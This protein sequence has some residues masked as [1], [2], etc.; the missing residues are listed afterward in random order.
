MTKPYN[1][2]ED[3]YQRDLVFDTAQGKTLPLERILKR[4][5]KFYPEESDPFIFDIVEIG[6]GNG[7]FASQLAQE[8]PDSKILALEIGKERFDSIVRKI[9]RLQLKNLT[10]GFGDA[11]PVLFNRLSK[12][13]VSHFY[14]LFPDPWPKNKHRHL[15]LMQQPLVDV[16]IQKLNVGGKITFISD[17]KDYSEWT[18]KLLSQ[19]P[20]LSN[21][22]S[23]QTMTQELPQLVSTYFKRRWEAMGRQFWHVRF[24]KN[25]SK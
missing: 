7:E 15:R 3:L 14:I 5:V 23:P 13:S 18:A 24:T 16:L 22:F 4:T 11:R 8:Q 17:V 6:A 19:S 12:D 25:V 2:L 21:D 10:A 20:L 1:R 9:D